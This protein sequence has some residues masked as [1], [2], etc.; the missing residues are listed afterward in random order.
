[1]YLLVCG[2]QVMYLLVC[3]IQVLLYLLLFAGHKYKN[4]STGQKSH[5]VSGE[6]SLRSNPIRL[7]E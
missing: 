3:G 5:T 1:V 2:T 4:C 7:R 6:P